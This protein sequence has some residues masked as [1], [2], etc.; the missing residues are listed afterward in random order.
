[1][2]F[3]PDCFSHGYVVSSSGAVVHSAAAAWDTLD[4][5]GLTYRFHDRTAYR[6]AA[7]PES[8][9]EP[10]RPRSHV[11]LIGQPIDLDHDT[12]DAGK[13]AEHALRLLRTAGPDQAIRYVAYLGGRFTCYL[14]RDDA[15]VEVVPD[16]HATQSIYWRNDAAGFTASSHVELVGGDGL[17]EVD[18]RARDLFDRLVRVRQGAGT[19]YLPGV[20]TAYD[21]VRPVLPNCLLRVDLAAGTAEHRRFYPFAELP[22]HDPDTAYAQFEQLFCQH[23]RLL[24]SLGRVGI[25]LTSGLDSR[26]TLAAAGDTLAPDSFAFTFYRASNTSPEHAD[27]LYEGNRLA[28]EYGLPH[29]VVKWDAPADPEFDV[30]FKA[31]FPR[32]PQARKL[33]SAFRRQLPRGFFHF[34]ST[35]AETGSG[36]YR[37][38]EEA[39]IS[40]R[41]LTHLWHGAE[42]AKDPAQVAA[43][44]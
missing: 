18:Q 29:R 14:H 7:E 24:G 23:V 26:V 6:H 40:P 1:M 28:W 9:A 27:D 21:A 32:F 42:V 2:T 39:E 44:D 37:R 34:Q 13:I 20:L 15:V 38:R 30:I 33:A 19:K 22:R 8:A 17:A 11:V 12:S 35:I 36:F 41:R 3:H 43:F 10:D 5:G 25:S 16:C 31:S 4:A